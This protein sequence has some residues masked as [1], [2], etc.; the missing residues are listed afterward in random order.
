[1]VTIPEKKWVKKMER[2]SGHFT[3]VLRK[4]AKTFWGNK[5]GEPAIP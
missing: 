2:D 4:A 3:N 5:N 1:M